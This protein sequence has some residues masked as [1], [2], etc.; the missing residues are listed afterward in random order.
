[1]NPVAS[2]SAVALQLYLQPQFFMPL[3]GTSRLQLI[4]V[5][6]RLQQPFNS[7]ILVILVGRCGPQYTDESRLQ[8]RLHAFVVLGVAVREPIG[9]RF[10]QSACSRANRFQYKQAD[11]TAASL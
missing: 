5:N 8:D 11:S 4:R 6:V 9:R 1:M 2:G 3:P 10:K 7:D